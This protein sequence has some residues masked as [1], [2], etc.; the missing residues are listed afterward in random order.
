MATSKK[1]RTGLD[2]LGISADISSIDTGAKAEKK[3]SGSRRS[4]AQNIEPVASP[5]DK[6]PKKAKSK[7][8]WKQKDAMKNTTVYVPEVVFEQWRELAFTERKKMHDYLL[9]GL[10]RVFAD[11]GLKSI[12]DLTGK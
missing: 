12:S 2:A 10:E 4:A 7:E 6:S 5:I 8:N 9:E 1:K 11:R 3:I